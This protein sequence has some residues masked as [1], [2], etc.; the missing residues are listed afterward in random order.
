MINDL[1]Q[2][3]AWSPFE[4]MDP[5]M[6]RTMSGPES[7]VGAAYAWEGNSKAGAG[8]MEITEST[9]SSNVKIKLDFTKPF[10]GHDAAEFTLLPEGDATKVTWAMTGPSPMMMKV[11]QVFMNMD[12]EIGAQ[13]E[14]GLGTLKANA[15]KPD[16]GGSAA[17]D[18]TAAK[19]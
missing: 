14:D 10:E 11:M 13:F 9:P 17:P 6:K 16:A 15:E 1:H 12:K 3:P 8:R 18:T 2:W 19:S 7:G 5:A 4:K